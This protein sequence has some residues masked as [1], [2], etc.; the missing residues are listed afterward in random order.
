MI[1]ITKTEEYTPLCCI[2]NNLFKLDES[3]I[4]YHSYNEIIYQFKLDHLFDLEFLHERYYSRAT[5]FRL[6][7]GVVTDHYRNTTIKI[8][9]VVNKDVTLDLSNNDWKKE[10]TFL[11]DNAFYWS[12]QAEIR[13]F[14][15]AINNYG[16]SSRKQIKTVDNL[17]NTFTID[18]LKP[19]LNDYE[20]DV[21]K[22]L[23][24]EFLQTL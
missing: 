23:S 8:I 10:V 13:R 16:F 3:N 9:T 20:P 6:G 2:E 22:V 24:E 15:T 12:C 19:S 17:H 21:Q 14:K 7:Y 11:I 18:P 1:Y 5:T 4:R